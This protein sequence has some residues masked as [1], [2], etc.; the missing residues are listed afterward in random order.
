MRRTTNSGGYI[1]YKMLLNEIK[2]MAALKSAKEKERAVPVK[3]LRSSTIRW[4]GLSII[5]CD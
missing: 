5:D 2:S 4:S 3:E 1:P